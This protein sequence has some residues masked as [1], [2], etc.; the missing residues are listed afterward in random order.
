[1]PLMMSVIVSDNSGVVQ[2]GSDKLNVTSKYIHSSSG[3]LSFL[4]TKTSP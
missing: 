2:N 1:M 4:V 3:L